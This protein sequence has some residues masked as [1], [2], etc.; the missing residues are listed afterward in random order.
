MKRSAT[1]ATLTA[2]GAQESCCKRAVHEFARDCTAFAAALES[3]VRELAALSHAPTAPTAASAGTAAAATALLAVLE[4]TVQD[5]EDELAA[6]DVMPGVLSGPRNL[7]AL[8]GAVLDQQQAALAQL[9]QMATELGYAPIARTPSSTATAAAVVA[10]T[11]QPVAP[12]V[13]ASSSST[14]GGGPCSLKPPSLADFGISKE[15]QQLLGSNAPSA[16]PSQ[17]S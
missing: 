6:V 17:S 12:A 5:A 8:V 3:Q 16:A 9:Q 15:T 4:D 13:P 10:P 7:A 11:P 2:G 1:A 14:G